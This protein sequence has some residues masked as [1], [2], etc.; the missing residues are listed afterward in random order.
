MP[1]ATVLYSVTAVVIAALLLWVAVVLKTAKEP[2]YRPAP[3]R[4][5]PADIELEPMLPSP[6]TSTIDA[7]ETA[8]ATPVALGTATPSEGRQAVAVE[9]TDDAKSNVPPAKA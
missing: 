2:W 8:K 7:D 9:A 5:V 3:P 4:L 6:G 1:E